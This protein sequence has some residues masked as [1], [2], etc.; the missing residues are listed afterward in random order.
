MKFLLQLSASIFITFF[1]ICANAADETQSLDDK[2]NNH[3]AVIRASKETEKLYDRRDIECDTVE[4]QE[5][6]KCKALQKSIDKSIAGELQLALMLRG[7]KNTCERNL[8]DYQS[9]L[10]STIATC[11]EADLTSLPQ[12]KKQ[13]LICSKD[14]SSDKKAKPKKGKSKERAKRGSTKDPCPTKILKKIASGNK[15]FKDLEDSIKTKKSNKEDAQELLNELEL[16]LIGKQKDL[17]EAKRDSEQIIQKALNDK[18]LQKNKAEEDNFKRK[19]EVQKIEFELQD[20]LTLTVTEKEKADQAIEDQENECY[21]IAIKQYNDEHKAC[22]ERKRAS[23]SNGSYRSQDG[24]AGLFSKNQPR[25]CNQSN[26]MGWYDK[27]QGY[28]QNTKTY[29]S[30]INRIKAQYRQS[31]KNINKTIDRRKEA[32]KNILTQIQNFEKTRSEVQKQ[33]LE[34]Q[35]VILQRSQDLALGLYE[36]VRLLQRKIG[37]AIE[38]LNEEQRDYNS[39]K[40]TIAGIQEDIAENKKLT[41][42]FD[43]SD[44]ELGG[45]LSSAFSG[46]SSLNEARNSTYISCDCKDGDGSEFIKACRDIGAKPGQENSSTGSSPGDNSQ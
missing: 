20:F 12:C 24:L 14:S 32:L 43:S 39:T 22:V 34:E 33:F 21:T 6:D 8:D 45:K 11:G 17:E 19:L 40:Q 31:I 30:R 16:E 42:G 46:I 35:R 41:E 1:V 23:I 10:K 15:E 25:S 4:K 26:R 44:I 37:K 28:C 3:P 7:T 27:Y 5:T 29:K 2:V 38:S 18:N 13:A 36:E 9:Q